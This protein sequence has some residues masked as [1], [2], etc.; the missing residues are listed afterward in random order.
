MSK[1]SKEQLESAQKT[2]NDFKE[3]ERQIKKQAKLARIQLRKDSAPQI[4]KEP[5]IERLK[6]SAKNYID[7]IANGEYIDDDLEHYMF[8]DIIFAFYGK[9]AWNWINNYCNKDLND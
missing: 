9:D 4:L 5:D 7:T 3:Q 8:E 1:I 2:I 6:N